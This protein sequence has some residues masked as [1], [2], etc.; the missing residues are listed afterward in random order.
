MSIKGLHVFLSSTFFIARV[1]Y[2]RASYIQ[3]IVY[4]LSLDV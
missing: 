3:I 2:I 1:L 4:E